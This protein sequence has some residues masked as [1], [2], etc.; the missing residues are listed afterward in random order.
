MYA[1]RL[2]TT[3]EDTW[4]ILLEN[5]AVG[6]AVCD[7]QCVIQHAN[8]AFASLFGFN[9]GAAKGQALLR[10]ASPPALEGTLHNLRRACAGEIRAF[11]FHGCHPH[12]L[13]PFAVMMAALP[14]GGAERTEG[15][16]CLAFALT[17]CRAELSSS[18]R[19]WNPTSGR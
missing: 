9:A 18:S 7:L 16:T 3:L 13:Q 10:L 14:L 17:G 2:D 12:T 15:V 19:C 6:L 11:I 1:D 5:P 8:P 4:R